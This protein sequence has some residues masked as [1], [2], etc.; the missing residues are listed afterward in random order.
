M[1]L[2][3]SAL[4]PLLHRCGCR[5]GASLSRAPSGP[6]RRG[7]RTDEV[8]FLAGQDVRP[9]EGFEE[10]VVDLCA[11]GDKPRSSVMA[12]VKMEVAILRA[13]QRSPHTVVF[14]GLVV[15]GP[16]AYIRTE[17]CDERLP[18]ALERLPE[19]T[20]AASVVRGAGGR[21]AP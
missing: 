1:A 12:A 16:L 20:E 8:V 6:S 3:D 14:L 9:G 15:E 4:H 18:V 7:R 2:R 19:L 17:R 13:L 10:K 21:A 5:A 11:G